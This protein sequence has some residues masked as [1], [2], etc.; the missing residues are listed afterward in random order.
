VWAYRYRI[1]GSRSKRPQVGGFSTRAPIARFPP[2]VSVIPRRA[3]DVAARRARRSLERRACV[4]SAER[5]QLPLSL[6]IEMSFS[7]RLVT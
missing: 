1:S 2:P 5:I 4:R 6:K 7:K 3:A